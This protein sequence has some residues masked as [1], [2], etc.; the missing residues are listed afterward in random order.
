MNIIMAIIIGMVLGLVLT[1]VGD[2]IETRYIECYM[3]QLEN[4]L[5]EYFEA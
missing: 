1:K 3:G 4:E 2:W 5:Q